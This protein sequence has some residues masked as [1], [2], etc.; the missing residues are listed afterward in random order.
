MINWG[1]LGL[2]RMGV[3]FAD[4]ISELSNSK[5]I[6]VGSNSN[7][8]YRDYKI[9]SYDEVLKN[10]NIDAI[11]IATLNN[12]HIDLIKKACVSKK[13]ILCEKPVS[14]NLNELNEIK[15]NFIAD[16]NCFYEAIAY[17]SH[18]Q[19][20]EILN[21]IK[22]NEIGEIVKIECSFGFKAKFNPAS[23]LFNKDLGGGAI[24]DLGCYPLSF[25]MLFSKNP[26]NIKINKKELEFS[27][28]G[29]DDDAKATLICDNNYECSIHVSIK[30]NLKNTCKIQGSNGY[31]NVISPWLPGKKT[32][33]EISNNNH[34][35][36]KTIET[37][38]S[39]Y[40][41]QIDNISNAFSNKNSN[42]S[43]LFDID[44]SLINMNLIEN[45]L[46]K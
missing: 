40:A 10:E 8:K 11:Y 9:F 32:Q 19:T 3:T 33:I 35:Y 1:I 18:P 30:N 16:K 5:L 43:N 31:I 24:Y 23:R 27:S 21:I 25:A 41:N 26:K 29:V 36:V 15:D 20:A 22:N 39:V 13:K 34:F 44:K 6:A 7:K 28:S 17:Y 45:W 38:L 12:S 46:Q 37:N 2:G 14:M 4:S 42:T